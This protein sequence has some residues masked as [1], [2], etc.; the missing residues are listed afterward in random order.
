MREGR[1]LAE[2]V[3]ILAVGL[4]G[5][6]GDLPP[7]VKE[8][9]PKM[10]YYYKAPD[11]KQGPAMLKDLLTKEN[12]GHPWFAKNEHVLML[13]GAQLGDIAAGKPE[14]VRAYEGEFA[15]APTAGRRVIVRALTN[16]GDKETLTQVVAWLDD[17][18]YEDVRAE[19]E[20]LNTHLQNPKRAHARDR[21]ARSPEDLD[22]L[23]VNFFITGEY[24]PVARILDVF[25]GPGARDDEVLVRVARWS[26][27]S[28]LQQHPKLVALVEAH[29][30]ER[31]EGSRKVIGQLILKSPDG[32][33]PKAAAEKAALVGKWLSDDDQKVPS[34]ST[35]AR[36]RWD[37]SRRRTIG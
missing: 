12:I 22:L 15:G 16:C 36:R 10:T 26:L 25:D 31:P 5:Q 23:W 13:V 34:F 18:R 27:E 8:W 6:Q 37:S 19:L 35:T 1:M 29:T 20:A 9:G 30:K 7:L 21:N 11:P 24:A 14:V 33:D 28:N 32:D 2:I 3:L 4:A 17:E